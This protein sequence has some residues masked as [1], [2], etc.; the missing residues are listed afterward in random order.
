[1]SATNLPRIIAAVMLAAMAVHHYLTVRMPAGIEEY[2]QRIR[3][4]AAQV[5]DHI[6][7]WV[8][9]DEAV[10]TQ[11]VN[12]LR[13][14]L[15]ISRRYVNLETGVSVGLLIVH[16]A[17]AHH[18]VGH[19]PLRCYP[20]RGWQLQSSQQRD[21]TAGDRT[22][23]GMEYHFTMSGDDS[24]MGPVGP[25]RAIVVDNCL[26]RPGMILRDMDGLSKSIVGA[27]GP[28]MGAAQIQVYCSPNLSQAQLDVAVKTLVEGY[29]PVLD[30]I[31][32]NP[33]K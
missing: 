17:D 5:P 25:D 32:S 6:G 21:W 2:D 8:S 20:L 16:C 18:M 19:Y 11:A 27:S 33:V 10:P 31:L 22:I 12:T 4:A 15:I 13:P 24:G 30:A 23:T 1:M 9:T 26:L 29:R 7:P 28:A 3:A 14:N